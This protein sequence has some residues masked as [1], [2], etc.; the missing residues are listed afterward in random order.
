MPLRFPTTRSDAASRSHG[1]SSTTA[2]ASSGPRRRP[3]VVDEIKRLGFRYATRGGMT[4]A[5]SDIAVP[6]DKAARLAEA[7][8]RYRHIE[9][10]YRRGLITDDERYAQV[11]EVWTR[12]R[13]AMTDAMMR[14]RSTRRP[15]H[16]DGRVGRRGNKGNIGQ[17]AGM[18]GLMADPS[19]RIIDAADPLELPRGPDRARVLP[20]DARRPQGSGR[21]RPPNGRLRAT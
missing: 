10:Q 19:G 14:S 5:L 9:R 16:D 8:E 15:G 2:T 6:K 11:V 17:M 3:Q 4:I 18:R 13:T 7:D 21:H 20:L 1:R 12:P